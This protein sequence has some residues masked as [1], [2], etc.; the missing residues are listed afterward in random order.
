MSAVVSTRIWCS[1]IVSTPNRYISSLSGSSSVAPSFAAGSIMAVNS[2]AAFSTRSTPARRLAEVEREHFGHLHAGLQAYRVKHANDP[3]GPVPHVD[4]Q[5][6][7]GPRV[8][9]CRNALAQ[10]IPDAR[11]L[12]LRAHP[13][14]NGSPAAQSRCAFPTWRIDVDPHQL[15]HS[16]G[17]TFRQVRLGRSYLD[18]QRKRFIKQLHQSVIRLLLEP[19]SQL[20]LHSFEK[21]G[22]RIRIKAANAA[23]VV[24]ELDSSVSRFCTRPGR[25]AQDHADVNIL[26]PHRVRHVPQQLKLACKPPVFILHLRRC[27]PPTSL[28]RRC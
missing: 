16:R 14:L 12:K 20:A 6:I 10:Q 17:D 23:P 19:P 7:P 27:R 25:L 13:C 8:L 3:V 24:R 5:R 28:F 22:V 26:V 21:R 9:R 15:F 1:S 11:A 2:S 4:A 18:V